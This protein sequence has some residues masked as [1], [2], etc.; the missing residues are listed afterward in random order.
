M[1]GQV[2]WH[3]DD[4]PG[5]FA[6]ALIDCNSTYISQQRGQDLRLICQEEGSGVRVDV[7]IKDARRERRPEEQI[8][9]VR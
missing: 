5:P 4:H 1:G 8:E 7:K 6:P 2:Y 3:L 9:H